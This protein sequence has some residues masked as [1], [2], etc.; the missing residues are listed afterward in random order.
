MATPERT[1]LEDIKA[2]LKRDYKRQNRAKIRDYL[3]SYK[4]ARGCANCRESRACCLVF[5][6]KNSCVKKFSL[7]NS[8][9]KAFRLIVGEVEKCIVLCANCHLALHEAG[10]LSQI[11]RMLGEE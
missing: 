1:T 6:H 5:H 3:Q 10:R 8:R 2:E 7:S 4:S 9:D 11:E